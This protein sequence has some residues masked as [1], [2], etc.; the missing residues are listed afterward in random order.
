[1]SEIPNGW[2]LVP[3]EPTEKMV[4][5][6][7][8]SPPDQFFSKLEDWDAYEEMTGCQQAA[9][10][11]RL[12]YAAMLAAAPE[13]WKVLPSPAQPAI[14]TAE[15][16]AFHRFC[17]C[18]EDFDSGG[19]DVPKEMM[20][21]L[22]RIG[23]VRSCGFGRYESTEFGDAVREAEIGKPASEQ[24]QV[25]ESA[26]TH[27][28]SPDEIDN[29]HKQVDARAIEVAPDHVCPACLG[30]PSKPVVAFM[31]T[32]E[33]W[34]QHYQK[35]VDFQ[36]QVCSTTGKVSDDVNRRYFEGRMHRHVRAQR[37]ELMRDAAIRLGVT[38]PQLSAWELGYAD[39]PTGE[40]LQEAKE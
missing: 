38:V 18:C 34:T 20:V 8:E 9:H 21:R 7:F 4:I 3:I 27:G 32:S 40:P 25:D 35:E 28:K 11:A 24:P 22:A 15:L 23:L 14:S 29:L 33:E 36:C 17:D 6:G 30:T 1:M 12:C 39:L 37:G 10:K 13:T 5:E 19:Y 16:A 26:K 31:N 2:K